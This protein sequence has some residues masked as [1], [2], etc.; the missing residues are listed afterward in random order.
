VTVARDS[1]DLLAMPPPGANID[2]R[3]PQ[4]KII[5]YFATTAQDRHLDQHQ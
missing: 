2:I 5:N 3:R 1:R 4:G